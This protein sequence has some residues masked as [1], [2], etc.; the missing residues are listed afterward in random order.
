MLRYILQRLGQGVLVL[1]ALY[2]IVFFLADLM[3]GDAFSTTERSMSPEVLEQQKK[4]WGQD[5]HILEQY[6][7]YPYNV[8]TKGTLGLSMEKNRPVWD[9]IQQ[10]FPASL[11][12][13]LAALGVAVGLGVPIGVLSAAR[14]NTAVDYG[15]MAI[16]MVGI[17]VPSF[18]IGPILQL[19]LAANVPALKIAGWGHPLDVLLPAV[20]LGLGTAAYLARLTRGAMLEVLNQD[21]IRTAHAKG[22]PGHR[23]V[24]KHA[25]RGGLLPAVAFIGPAF[26]VLISG[27]F[28]VE[29]IFQ[30]PGMGQHFITAALKRDIYVLL[31]VVLFYGL[32]IVIMNLAADL[33]AAALNPRIRLHDA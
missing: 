22:L 24:L 17:C 15:G 14:K 31:G 1:W 11:I 27:S 25:L 23:V 2:T 28:I 20:T 13:G 16:A 7:I 32:L 6:I 30:V 12:V 18:I 26:A 19:S 4:L 21:F 33:L 8:V 10:S 9:I 29:T 3:P 5:K